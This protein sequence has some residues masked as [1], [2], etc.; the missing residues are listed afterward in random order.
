MQGPKIRLRAP[1]L[2]FLMPAPVREIPVCPTGKPPG[3]Y[4]PVTTP[5]T[6][7][8]S[9]TALLGPLLVSA[10]PAALRRISEAL[11]R[12]AA[13]LNAKAAEL[14]RIAAERARRRRRQADRAA[15]LDAVRQAIR[16]GGDPAAAVAPA[17][18]RF[19]VDPQSLAAAARVDRRRWSATERT[20]RNAEIIRLAAAGWPDREIAARVGLSLRQV[21]AIVRRGIAERQSLQPHAV[22]GQ[23][24]QLGPIGG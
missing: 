18:R 4:A 21:N 7:A 1:K 17:A 9:L 6:L 5:A 13:M 2:R 12:E 10:D 16:D 19:G 11:A 23:L 3:H 22:A 14:E 24:G 8:V 15:A 20:H